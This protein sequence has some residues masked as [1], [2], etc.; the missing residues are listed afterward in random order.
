MPVLILRSYDGWV[1]LT[2]EDGWMVDGGWL[3]PLF[4]SRARYL[5]NEIIKQ[6]N[7]EDKQCPNF[8]YLINRINH[9]IK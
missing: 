8:G 2:D 9:A 6:F 7:W 5:S 3:I 4:V 1:V